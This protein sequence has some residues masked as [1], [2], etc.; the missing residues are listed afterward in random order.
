MRN[1]SI[2]AGRDDSVLIFTQNNG[3]RIHP[4]NKAAQ[5]RSA[6]KQHSVSLQSDV[7][8]EAHNGF[9]DQANSN[10]ARTD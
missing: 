1:T 2:L 8:L 10:G 5:G 6:W 3:G 9:A 4:S 7:V